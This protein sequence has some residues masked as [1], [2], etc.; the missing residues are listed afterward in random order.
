M[1]RLKFEKKEITQKTSWGTILHGIISRIKRKTRNEADH[2]LIRWL[3]KLVCPR[4]LFSFLLSF[5]Q[6][7]GKKKPFSYFQRMFLSS[8]VFSNI[9]VKVISNCHLFRNW[10]G[11]L[12]EVFF[13]FSIGMF[14]DP[15]VLIFEWKLEQSC[16]SSTNHENRIRTYVSRLKKLLANCYIVRLLQAALSSLALIFPI[17]EQVRAK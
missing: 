6:E 7:F 4:I 16:F 15:F 10:P 8:C 1:W 5:V 2:I 3:A 9:I 17:S 13:I 14:Y 11:W 12:L